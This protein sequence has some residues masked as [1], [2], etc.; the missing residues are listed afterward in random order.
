MVPQSLSL[1]LRQWKKLK[2]QIVHLHDALLPDLIS[3]HVEDLDR[4]LEQL[5][6]LTL[7][8]QSIE[9]HHYYVPLGTCEACM[10]AYTQSCCMGFLMDCPL[11]P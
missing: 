8:G 7:K 5:Q 11:G 9:V 6:D 2:I 3:M 1:E 4:V 10:A